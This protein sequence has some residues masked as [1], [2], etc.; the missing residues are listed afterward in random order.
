MMNHMARTPPGD[1]ASF[2]ACEMRQ[3]IATSFRRP[4]DRSWLWLRGSGAQKKSAS[5][6]AF[7]TLGDQNR[8]ITAGHRVI[9]LE[10]FWECVC[11]GS[12]TG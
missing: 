12:Y 9:H 1:F 11:P 4:T 2:S 3:K 6:V 5:Q 10:R 8:E 7:L